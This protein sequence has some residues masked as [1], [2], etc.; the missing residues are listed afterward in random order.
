MGD[1]NFSGLRNG[2]WRDGRKHPSGGWIEQ[3]KLCKKTYQAGFSNSYMLLIRGDEAGTWTIQINGPRPTNGSL[4]SVNLADAKSEAYSIADRHFVEKGM[5]RLGL[6]LGL[7]GSAAAGFYSYFL[8][9]Q[10]QNSYVAGVL[11]ESL[12]ADTVGLV[13]PPRVGLRDPVGNH[14]RF[15]LDLGRFFKVAHYRGF[16]GSAPLASPHLAL[17]L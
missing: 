5:R 4:E 8:A 15:S 16:S 14:P 13:A 3:R 17:P 10:V 1:L 6:L 9:V 12:L 11:K 2:C 7:L